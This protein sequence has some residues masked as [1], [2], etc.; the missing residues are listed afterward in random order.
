[1]IA[2]DFSPPPA[3]L[4]VVDAQ[5]F[6]AHWDAETYA[7]LIAQPVVQAW[8]LV[9][10]GGAAVGLLCFQRVGDEAEVYRIAVLP[11]LRGQ[12]LG[13]KL[14]AR[15]Q[16]GPEGGSPR[17]IHLEVRAAN[18]AARRLY[19]RTGFRHVGT[20]RGYYRQPADDAACYR[21]EAV[22][23]AAVPDGSGGVR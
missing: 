13:R 4:A 15:L 7:R 14:L 8:T 18:A 5:C 11:A 21:W 3:A 6:D 12:G 2:I 22:S 1:M 19:E 9:E 23:P 20:R 16:D 10:A 17:V